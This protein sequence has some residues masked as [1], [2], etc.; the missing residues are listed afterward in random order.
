MRKI[1]RVT[2]NGVKL[3]LDGHGN[4]RGGA[5]PMAAG[6]S[7]LQ[8]LERNGLVTIEYEPELVRCDHWGA[9]NCQP[10]CHHY[11]NHENSSHCVG[12]NDCYGSVCTCIPNA[13]GWAAGHEVKLPKID[14]ELA[15]HV[16]EATKSCRPNKCE[17]GDDPATCWKCDML[18]AWRDG[19]LDV[20]VDGMWTPH[21]EKLK[22]S[23]VNMQQCHYRRRPNLVEVKQSGL[24]RDVLIDIARAMQDLNN[25]V[26]VLM[27]KEAGK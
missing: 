13:P 18:Q 24:N 25:K 21:L 2:M 27:A 20:I 5:I 12:E 4:W 8:D 11:T 6:E 16:F 15:K 26:A 9:P 7:Q 19:E 14:H 17:H 1:K 23:F 3:R 22:P 10:G